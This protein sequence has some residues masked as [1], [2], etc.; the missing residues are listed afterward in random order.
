MPRTKQTAEILTSYLDNPP[1]MIFFKEWSEMNIGKLAVMKNRQAEIDYPG[2]YYRTLKM[3]EKYPYGENPND[4]YE[5]IK[6]TWEELLTQKI[7][8]MS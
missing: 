5:R 6:A 8:A 7:E 3:N 1:E 4:F 2:L